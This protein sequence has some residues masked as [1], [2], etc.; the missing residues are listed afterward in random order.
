[1]SPHSLFTQ[2]YPITALI[3]RCGHPW[4]RCHQHSYPNIW[5]NN[6]R[7]VPEGLVA[8][9]D[10]VVK[11]TVAHRSSPPLPTRHPQLW[12]LI[13]S[14]LIVTDQALLLTLNDQP[15]R[16]QACVVETT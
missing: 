2:I 3:D 14:P 1:M 6:A 15:N 13:P 7:Y 8:Y 4:C 9:V 12:S 5:D 10:Q 16:R 11:C